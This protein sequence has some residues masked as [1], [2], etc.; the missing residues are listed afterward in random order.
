MVQRSKALEW[1][2]GVSWQAQAS[3]A[4]KSN[5][6]G[7]KGVP[8]K[9]SEGDWMVTRRSRWCH[10]GY[11]KYVAGDVTCCSASHSSSDSSSLSSSRASCVVCMRV[12][13]CVCKLC[14]SVCAHTLVSQQQ[15]EC[16]QRLS[17]RRASPARLHFAHENH[18]NTPPHTHT[19]TF[20][21]VR[22]NSD[23]AFDASRFT[24]APAPPAVAAA[25]SAIS[26]RAIHTGQS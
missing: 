2:R 22:L 12:F 5:L 9:T 14:A 18:A 24:C 17:T 19:L 20:S 16:R 25:T 11:V 23:S 26:T 4:N 3:E 10:P 7:A 13:V 1:A 8:E 15:L 6:H 21:C